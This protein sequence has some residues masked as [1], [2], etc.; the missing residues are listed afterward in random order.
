MDFFFSFATVNLF[1]LPYHFLKFL[2]LAYFAITI[3][4]IIHIT[5]KICVNRLFM[6][7]VRSTVGYQ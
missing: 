6:L 1:S 4:Y 3:Q 7:S 2:S 5:Y